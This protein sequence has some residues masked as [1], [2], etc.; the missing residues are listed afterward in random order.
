M[1]AAA[2]GRPIEN[3]LPTETDSLAPRGRSQ[4]RGAAACTSVYDALQRDA[5]S[6]SAMRL[7]S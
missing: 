4:R 5:P 1:D 2:K 7:C 6:C 3:V